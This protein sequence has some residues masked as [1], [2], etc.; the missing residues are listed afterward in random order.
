M[1][2]PVSHCS[3]HWVEPWA[4]RG[5]R[6]R[7]CDA[8][9]KTST[10]K[11]NIY[12]WSWW[13][14][15]EDGISETWRSQ[16]AARQTGHQRAGDD[17]RANTKTI[18]TPATGKVSKVVTEEWVSPELKEMVE[19]TETPPNQKDGMC[20]HF[21]LTEIRRGEPDEGLFYPPEGYKIVSEREIRAEHQR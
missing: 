16:G 18:T 4:H 19:L 8:R 10:S 17:R 14:H 5:S 9:V 20:L 21:E 3:F 11:R 2:D 1:I 13:R 12:F 15:L 6:P 7:W